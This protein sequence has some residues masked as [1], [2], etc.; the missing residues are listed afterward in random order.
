M[1]TVHRYYKCLFF[2]CLS[3]CLLSVSF[4]SRSSENGVIDIKVG[5]LS[6][7][8]FY[9]IHP[10]QS[11]SGVLVDIMEKTLQRTGLSYQVAEYP[12]KRLY[13][14]LGTGETDLFLGIKG[15]LEY[16]KNVLYSDV[17]VSQIQMRIYAKG[18]TPLPKTKE[19]IKG[20]SI[21]T[22][23]G[24]SYGGLV[25]YF[26]DPSNNIAMTSTS[27]HRSSFLMLKNN[28]AD[29]LINYKHP[30]ETVLKDLKISELKY[31]NYYAAN[32]HFI[33]SK[34]NPNALKIMAKLEQAYLELIELGQ[35]EY[36]ENNN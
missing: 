14:N 32:V 12:T 34:A 3:T 7:P 28:R 20:H 35:L 25:N 31:T 2:L 24:Y 22:I 15:P 18:K 16:D 9:I 23:R 17:A 8:P 19:D 27:E 33:V 1:V 13:N 6:F 5:I 11:V 21:I 36:I 10:D 29:Y 4:L 26:V 30:S